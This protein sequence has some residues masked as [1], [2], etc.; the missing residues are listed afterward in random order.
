MLG[1]TYHAALRGAGHHV[2]TCATAQA[3]ILAA[4]NIFPDIVV[5]ELQLV[6][7]SGVEFLYEFRSYADWQAVPVIIHSNVPVTQFVGGKSTLE[8][9]GVA[10]YFYKPTTSLRTLIG[11][12]A[13]HTTVPA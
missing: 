7:H 10:D 13:Q 2:Q 12:I 3:A 5:L 11:A 1:Q 6:S 8:Q 9:F 4:D